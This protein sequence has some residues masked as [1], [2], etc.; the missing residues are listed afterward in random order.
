MELHDETYD[1]VVRYI[2]GDSSI[3]K[4]T[5]DW[6]IKIYNKIC[7]ENMRKYYTDN[8]LYRNDMSGYTKDEAHTQKHEFN[9]IKA[10][11]NMMF[12]RHHII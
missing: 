1:M 11:P 7:Y 6:E 9:A 2:N 10:N 3:N 12:M 4:E 8:N 5:I